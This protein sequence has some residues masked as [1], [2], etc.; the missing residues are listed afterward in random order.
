VTL[1]I[2]WK[3]KVV[4]EDKRR[5]T[6]MERWFGLTSGSPCARGL[7][8]GGQKASVVG[9]TGSMRLIKVAEI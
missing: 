6:R 7:L 3:K 8:G 9:V 5:I 4:G 1:E 2:P